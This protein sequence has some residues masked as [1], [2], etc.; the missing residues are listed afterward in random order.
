MSIFARRLQTVS[1]PAIPTAIKNSYGGL[2]AATEANRASYSPPLGQ[3]WLKVKWSDLEPTQGNYDWS[4]IDNYLNLAAHATTNVRIHV[5]GGQLAPVSGSNTWLADISGGTVSVKN[6]KDVTTAPCGLYWNPAYMAAYATFVAAMGARY[7]GNPRVVSINN[8]GC[9]LIYDEPWIMGGDPT[10]CINMFNAGLTSTTQQTAIYNALDALMA[11]W[12]TTIIEM[13]VHS[14]LNYPVSS[15]QGGN[16]TND[17]L[18][19]INQLH[20]TYGQRLIITDYGLGP[21]EYEAAAS[22][23]ATAPSVYSWMHKRSDLGYPIAF[24]ATFGTYNQA[25]VESGTQAAIDMG[26][27]WYE[28][29]SWSALPNTEVQAYDTALKANVH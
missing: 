9:S 27:R 21:G 8:A 29:S 12:P 7:D 14:Q 18:P 1:S 25:N 3:Y 15:G 11:A 6:S 26:G 17:G 19:A 20:T 16:W 23:L 24:Q 5:Q 13:P 10:S 22:S 4:S 28:T 2:F